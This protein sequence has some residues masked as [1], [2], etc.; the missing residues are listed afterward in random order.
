[1]SGWQI[2]GVPPVPPMADLLRL[3][4]AQAE[5]LAE[6]PDTLRQLSGSVRGLAETAEATRETVAAAQ[7][8]VERMN[9]LLEELEDPVRGLRPGIE[10]VTQ[11][12][13]SPVWERL[14][15]LLESVE[16]TV[17]PVTE[18]AKHTRQRLAHVRR[19]RRDLVARV[20]TVMSDV[21]RGRAAG[22]SRS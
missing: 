2:P 14:P 5:V 4:Q 20:R 8:V 22:S 18:T 10:R 7:R 15:S 12:L 9:S 3:M 16:S 19:L 6:L 21:A 17:L 13:D 11:V 1:M